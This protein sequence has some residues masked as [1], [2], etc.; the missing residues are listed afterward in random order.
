MNTRLNNAASAG[1]EHGI[2]LMMVLWIL[3]LLSIISMNFLTSTRWG[4]ASVR[5]F[6]EDT[7]AYYLALSGY[8]EAVNYLA[9]DKD[10]SVDFLD[11]E[12]TFWIDSDTPPITGK[13]T[14]EDGEYE[15]RISDENG[16]IN[17]NFAT[18]DRLSKLF[19]YCGVK[20]DDLNVL[21]DSIMDWKDPD[22]EHR[23]S[24]AE[25]DYYEALPEPYKA[26]NGFFDVPEELA[27]VRGMKAEYLYGT[28]EGGIAVMPLITTFGRNVINI[29]TASKEVL[30]VLGLNVV[31]IETILKQRDKNY[32]G[33]RFIPQ[34]FSAR[35]LNAVAT[36][37][38]RIEVLAKMNNSPIAS[39]VTGILYRQPSAEGVKLQTI[40]WSERAE[41][42]RG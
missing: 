33:F 19:S 29:N 30:E 13:H 25:D 2:A 23:L 36:Q 37:N 22:S 18:E 31:E 28:G 8:Q 10:L 4:S 40:Y 1:T 41:T 17:I 39:R 5:N 21:I 16:R 26:K 6:K 20:Q 38:F 3:V 7:Q 35:G 34:Q 11:G 9:S 15:I 42:V 27:L 14:T 12:G 24:G 32:G